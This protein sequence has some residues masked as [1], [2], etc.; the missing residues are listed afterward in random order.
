MKKIMIA[1][2]IVCAAVVSQGANWRWTAANI[3]DGA[4]SADAAKMPIGTMAYIF[5]VGTVSMQSVLDNFQTDGWI[6]ENSLNSKS[7]A[8]A[9]QITAATSDTDFAYG[10][11]Q[12]YSFFFAIVDGDNLYLSNIKDAT[13]TTMQ[14]STAI[15]FGGQA[16]AGSTYSKDLPITTGVATAGHWHAVPEPTSGLL[17]LLGVAG[18]ALRRRRA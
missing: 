16:T 8:N 1:A 2:A 17:L 10:E 4:G 3:Y 14:G 7:L 18:L 9:G 6:A 15:G 5:D 12:K 13:G 11:A